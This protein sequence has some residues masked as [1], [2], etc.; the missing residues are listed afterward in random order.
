MLITFTGEKNE[1]IKT[2][3]ILNVKWKISNTR[4][5]A[6]SRSNILSNIKANFPLLM[7]DFKPQIQEIAEIFNLNK[8]KKMILRPFIVK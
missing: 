5:N 1:K 7:K 6:W 4:V 3:E 2:Q 8:Y